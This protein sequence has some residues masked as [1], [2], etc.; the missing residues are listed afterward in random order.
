M[1][2]QF[3]RGGTSLL[4]WGALSIGCNASP[5]VSSISSH[6]TSSSGE[7]LSSSASG[8]I[9]ENDST[10]S[11]I[12]CPIPFPAAVA[13]T[14]ETFEGLELCY[15]A[16]ERVILDGGKFIPG[17][18]LADLNGDDLDDVFIVYAGPEALHVYLSD[19]GCG[20][21]GPVVVTDEGTIWR[22]DS[23]DANNDGLLDI[24][25]EAKPSRLFLNKGQ[26]S[27]L[28]RSIPELE[29]LFLDSADFDNDTHPDIVSVLGSQIDLLMGDGEGNFTLG[30][31]I[32]LDGQGTYAAAM[33]LNEDGHQDIVTCQARL[34]NDFEEILEG[35]ILFGDPS[36]TFSTRVV[37][38]VEAP[39]YP[40]E[41]ASGD[42]NR[43]GHADFAAGGSIRLGNGHGQFLST[44]TFPGIFN[45]IE[46]VDFNNDGLMDFLLL[47]SILLN[48]DGSFSEGFENIAK[49]GA[50]AG[51]FNG[52][53]FVDMIS[54]PKEGETR[55]L[56]FTLGVAP[57]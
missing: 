21:S 20:F 37:Y 56:A 40:F 52:D 55:Y 29:G 14:C 54:L 4:A 32:E 13:R 5:P 45:K 39:F 10:T 8:L 2:F 44:Q 30:T 51:N 31:Q 57:P 19:P 36:L 25:A 48:R 12:D 7:L 17:I 11:T 46:Q 49:L 38:D 42:Y 3:R 6:D 26:G 28:E 34:V 9:T 47:G 23:V 1:A 22:A 35:V 18:Y 50:R 27:F 53:D 16:Q 43:D 41:I 24:I 33:D 15:T